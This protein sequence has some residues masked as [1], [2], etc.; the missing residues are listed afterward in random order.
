MIGYKMIILFL[1]S[2]L[3]VLF[4]YYILFILL[5]WTLFFA[6]YLL[7]FSVIERFYL[8]KLLMAVGY[9]SALLTSTF[10]IGIDNNCY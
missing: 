6:N 5:S 7:S 1:S 2:L 8:L 9:K 3:G 4:I 10:L